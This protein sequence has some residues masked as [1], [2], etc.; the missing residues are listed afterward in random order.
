M[1]KSIIGNALAR[2]ASRIGGQLML[3]LPDDLDPGI[4]AQILG[5]ANA[6]VPATPPFGLF[7]NGRRE[8]GGKI[9]PSVDFRELAMYRQGSRLAVAYASENRGMSTYSSVYPLLLSNG[10]PSAGSA[11]GGTGVAS[12]PEFSAS[13]ADVLEDAG[14]SH[15]LGPAEFRAGI[16]GVLEFLAAAYETVGNGQSSFAADWWMHVVQWVECLSLRPSGASYPEG[17]PRLYGAAGLPVPARGTALAIKAKNYIAVLQSRWS[18]PEA[19]RTELGR[20]EGVG[21]AKN[22]AQSLSKVDWEGSHS[23]ICL[24]SD[25]PVSLVAMAIGSDPVDRIRGWSCLTEVDFEKSFVEAKGKLAFRR[26]GS[27]LTPPW[28]HALPV[29][30]ASPHELS[31]R[32]ETSLYLEDLVL[33]VP[34]KPD[35]ERSHLPVRAQSLIQFISVQ[36]ARGC[37]ATL[38]VDA[39]E[40]ELRADGLHLPGRLAIAT[41]KKTHSLAWIEVT[42][43]GVASRYL[44]DRCDGSF[45]L[46]RP[47]EAALWAKPN[48]VAKR[49]SLRGPIVWS[50]SLGGP[51]QVQLPEVGSYELALAWG[52]DSGVSAAA[53]SVR[54]SKFELAWPG[55]TDGAAKASI[56]ISDSVDVRSSGKV[57]FQLDLT[58]TEERPLSPIVAAAHGLRPDTSVFL[59]E[60]TLSYFESIF[61][62]VLS[63]LAHGHA[64]GCIHATNSSRRSELVERQPGV[65][66][67]PDQKSRTGADLS[68][69]FPSSDLLSHTAYLNLLDSYIGLGIPAAIAAIEKDEGV[70][71]L[72]V[73]RISLD[74]ISREAM[75][76]VLDAYCTLLAAAETLSPSD[77][78]WAKN[79]FSLVVCREGA[80]FQSAQAVLM[81]PLHPIRLAWAWSLHV[82]LLEAH[83]DGANPSASLALLDGSNLPSFVSFRDHFGT[84]SAFMPVGVDARPYDLYLGWHASVSLV[85]NRADI[86]EW[87]AGLRFPVDGLSTLSTAAVGA[88]I[89]DFLRVSPHVQTLQIELASTSPSRRSSSIDEGILAKIAELALA[90]AGLDG[91]A[92]VRVVDSENRLGAIPRFSSIED[93]FA[94]SRP[95]FNADWISAPGEKES[96]AHVTFL[97]GTAALLQMGTRKTYGN[98]WLPNLPLRRTP[99]RLREGPCTVLD[100]S[101]PDPGNEGPSFARTLFA[102]ETAADGT[103]VLKIIPNPIGVAGKPSWLVAGDFGVDPQALSRAARSQ[104]GSDYI[105]WDWRPATT[106]KPNR[107]TSRRARPYF[108]LAS[109]PASLNNAIHDR[110]RKLNGQIPPQEVNA[111]SREL[112]STLA[113]RAIGL[114]TLLAIGHHQATGALGFYFALRS[115]SSWLDHALEGEIRLLIPVDAVD[116]FLRASYIPTGDGSRKRADLLAVRAWL[117]RE[118]GAR[119]VLVPIEI[120]HYGL[121]NDEEGASFPLAGDARLEE[122]VEQLASYQEQ[123]QNLCEAYRNAVGSRA[124]LLG[125]RLA[126]VLDAAIQ[127]S[128]AQRPGTGTLLACVAAAKAEVELGKGLLLWYQAGANGIDGSKASWDG[129]TGSVVTR[130]NDVRIDPKA[131]DACFWGGADGLAHAVVRDALEDASTIDAEKAEE[132]PGVEDVSEGAKEQNDPTGQI[133]TSSALPEGTSGSMSDLV[134]ADAGD[135]VTSDDIG[136]EQPIA[137]V[138]SP[139]PASLPARKKLSAVTL[140]R[141]Y[142]SLLASLSEFGVKVERPRGQTPYQEGPAFI[143]YAVF[144]SYGVS[145]SRIESQLE[146]LKLR[147][148]L[149]SDAEI[150]CS[151]HMGNVLLTVPKSEEER[152]FVDTKDLW[153]RWQRPVTGFKIPVGEDATGDV[154]EVDLANS[155]S[156]HLLIAGVTGS[157]KSEALLTILHGAAHFYSPDELRLRLIDPKQTELNSLSG[158]PHTEGQIGWTAEEAIAL[159]EQAVEEM[160]RRYE[161]FRKAGPGIRSVSD[162]QTLIAP[163]AR[164]IIVLDEYADLVSVDTERK[165]IEKCLQRL[166]QKARAA[167]IHVIV[168]TQKPVVQVVNTVVKGNLPGR[169]AL[170]VSTSTE[171]RVILDESGAEQLVGKGDALIRTGN[172]KT[173]VQFGRYEI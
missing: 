79:P 66:C 59:E 104:A 166:S 40:V 72:T 108:V 58:S 128:A 136:T 156:P 89:D 143:E 80:G 160:E 26:H 157:G 94:I 50:T 97:E 6:E 42:V 44:A 85:E 168:S 171:S 28:K 109:V 152:Y 130:R 23:R 71:G 150:G 22:A 35:L 159:L 116:P 24:R 138:T 21:S 4:V 12:L 101:L 173:R 137:L 8:E 144:P 111:R 20:L 75:D 92:G 107:E 148:K 38:E 32:S 83:A 139:A 67:S 141:R 158:L 55:M 161:L 123:L 19:I 151:T 68:P 115:I 60:N 13:L 110:L 153:A 37:T 17:I 52:E 146:N 62:D 29:I 133:A 41:A 56:E 47:D 64:L 165:A 46:I 65:L 122:H 93:A 7:V 78:F 162:Y 39:N 11:T 88:A 70:A 33:V 25:S 91:V 49:S 169:I 125:Q 103:H 18:S 90:S 112:I 87:I 95:G 84:V 172:L 106:T 57:L 134:G 155:N 154:V 105:L 31:D 102:Y 51:A 145:V 135:L 5:G 10:F 99:A 124:S 149:P 167:G 147:L 98:G 3:E 100:Y 63:N 16:H 132:K 131:F 36:G 9:A 117:D 96:N 69:G 121:G 15:G 82:G 113:E 14:H 1:S 73:S 2:L 120:K 140:E 74:F 163:L 45:T 34:Y 142:G 114:N 30:V 164:W 126:A 53:A 43:T 77:Q 76:L 118:R 119:V 127:L 61:C 27:D 54:A 129:I 81:S 48:G 86:P 170:R